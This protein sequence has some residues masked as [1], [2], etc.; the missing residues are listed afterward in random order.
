MSEI[1]K[2]LVLEILDQASSLETIMADM[3]TLFE[4]SFTEDSDFWKTLAY[5]ELNHAALIKSVKGN[6]AMSEQYIHGAP[7]D[8]LQEIVK[9]KEWATSLFIKFSEVKPDRVTAFNTAI[10]AEKT[11]GE[12][13]FQ[14][15]MTKESDSWLI[16]VLQELNEYD[17]DHLRRI[18]EYVKEKNITL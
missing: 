14:S 2:L 13:H 16:K 11:A 8:L 12:L 1:N 15:I 17:R 7:H 10:E 3:Y 18:E 5:E 6:P 4:K 9:A